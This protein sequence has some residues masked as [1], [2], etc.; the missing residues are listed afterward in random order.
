[1]GSVG[2]G[3]TNMLF[4]REAARVFYVSNGLIDPFFWDI[5]GLCDQ[6][7]SWFFAQPP[8]RFR[9]DVFDA[10]YAVDPEAL[11]AALRRSLD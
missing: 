10:D 8:Q 7:F 1:M 9:Q 4:A 6:R 2:A 5:A 3:L 11:R